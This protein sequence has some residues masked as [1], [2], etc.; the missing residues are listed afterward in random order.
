MIDRPPEEVFAGPCGECGQ[1]LYA[2]V[3]APL[4]RCPQ[5]GQVY[6]TEQRRSWLLELVHDQLATGPEISQ[7]LTSLALPVTPERIRQWKARNRLLPRGKN[8]TGRPLYR[9]GD[10]AELLMGEAAKGA[11]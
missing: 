10:V 7:A 2:A 3:G 1:D 6:D 5:C 11:S 4:V 8:Q 9:V